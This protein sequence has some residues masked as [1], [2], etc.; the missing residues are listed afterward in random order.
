[1]MKRVAA[2]LVLLIFVIGCAAPS[3][4]KEKPIRLPHSS[5]ADPN[6]KLVFSLGGEVSILNPILSTDSASSAV[7]GTIFTGMTKINKKL[8]VIPDLAKSWKVSKDG[9]TWTF[10]LRKDVKWHD[11]HPFTAEDVVFTFNS[12]LDPKVNSVRRSNFIIDGEPI[13]FKALDKYT[14]QA[15]LPKPFAPFLVRSGMSVIPK[16]LL[17]GKDI[18]TAKFNRKPIG[19]GPFKFKEWV[20]GDHVSV[21]RNPDYYLG[22]P[23]LAE[24]I[25]KVI[26]DSNAQLVALEAGEI[27][28]AGIPPKDYKRMKATEGINVFEY[29]SLLY[30]YLG[31]NMANPKFKD[32]RVRHA[33]AYATNK[34]QLVSLIFKGLASPAYAPSSPVS[35][36]YSDKVNKYPY[37]PKKAKK[38]LKEAGAEN[39]EFTILVNQGNK[40]REKAAVVL[41]QQYKKVGVKVNIRVMEWSAMLKVI[42]TPKA[43][44]DF[45]AVI[46]GWSLGLDPDAYSIWHSSQYPKGFN[47]INYD[48]PEADKLLEEG[49]TTMDKKDRKKIYAEL[50]ETIAEDQPYVFLWYPKSIIGVS[51]RVGGLEEPGP[52]G[53]F[54]DIEKVFVTKD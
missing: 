10:Y 54:L 11:G 43:P 2:L 35:W 44:K 12:I 52:A 46:I 15:I 14:V 28:S 53:V 8:E 47:F 37:N 31:L 17:K 38:M 13:K 42:N 36:A 39:L 3:S 29:D 22:K 24:I 6:G 16:H 1:M 33:L 23:K 9:K 45:D 18:N 26:P 49:R 25:Y 30:T 19:T 7:E 34:K 48:N 41:Q 51:E 21:V 32:K 20:T 50:W 40:E 27:D 4:Q 5:Q